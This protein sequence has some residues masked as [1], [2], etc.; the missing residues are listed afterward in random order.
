[1]EL[2]A[3]RLKERAR[4]LGI[5]NS[6]VARRVGLEERRYG[7]YTTGRNEPDLETLK[8]IADVLGTT[9]NWL[10]GVDDGLKD[11]KKSELLARFENAA[12]VMSE[13]ELELSIIQAEAI[14]ASK[15]ANK[16][17]K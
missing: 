8:Q 1:M 15:D 12:S 6:E 10:L 4:Q 9:P 11:G 14:A 17:G 16:S 13:A 3:N 5:S 7:H 2:F